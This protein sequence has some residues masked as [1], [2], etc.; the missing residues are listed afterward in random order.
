MEVDTTPEL[1]LAQ[2]WRADERRETSRGARP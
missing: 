1:A 2:G